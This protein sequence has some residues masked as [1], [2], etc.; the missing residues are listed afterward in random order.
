MTE[1]T[2]DY[3]AERLAA[4]QT[5]VEEAMQGLV[6]ESGGRHSPLLRD[7]DSAVAV[8]ER[9]AE[10][11]PRLQKALVDVE[12]YTTIIAMDLIHGYDPVPDGKTPLRR[13]PSGPLPLG[14]QRRRAVER[15]ISVEDLEDVRA[16]AAEDAPPEEE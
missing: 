4:A 6:A 9:R 12:L 2:G 3:A 16:F 8:F 13:R 7:E 11:S 14:E 1:T 10:R 15:G 5:V